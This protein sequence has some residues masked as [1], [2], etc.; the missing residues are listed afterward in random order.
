[1]KDGE[2]FLSRHFERK[3]SLAL[4][5]HLVNGP[6]TPNQMSVLSI[7]VGLSGAWCMGMGTRSWQVAGASLFLAH[8]I[9]DGCD[10]EIA[11]VKMQES[12]LGGMLDFWGDNVVHSAVFGAIAWDWAARAD[13]G[14]PLLLG[15][16][17]VGGTFA[18][19]TLIWHFTLRTH[20]EE[21]PLYTS[22]S[23]GREK[24][25]FVRLADFLTRRDF[26]YLV[27]LLALVGHLDW[28]L[29]AGAFG[30]PSFALGLAWTY[31]RDK[32]YSCA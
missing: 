19:A 24:G 11:R 26:I 8:S 10:G 9:L 27:L 25:A 31:R 23:T 2:G 13:A 22:V 32:F 14:W 18:S 30:T 29:L 1:V 12:R 21:G 16:L 4:T 20:R 28:F 5:R 6:M 15:A 7:L 3:L 17:A